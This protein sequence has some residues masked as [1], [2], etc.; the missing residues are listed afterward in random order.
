[1]RPDDIPFGLAL[2][3]IAGWNQLEQDWRRILDLNPQCVYVAEREGTACGTASIMCCSR[4]VA[5]I[6]MV[7]VHPDHR[8][9]GVGSTLMRHCIDVL[10]EAR[11][12]CTKLDATEQGRRVYQKL[13][14]EDERPICRYSL[15]SLPVAREVLHPAIADNDWLSVA[16][17]DHAAFGADRLPLLRHMASDCFTAVA[18]SPKGSRGFGFARIGFNASHLGPIVAASAECAGGL[19]TSLLAQLPAH[20]TVYW[21]GFPD[22]IHARRLAE[23]MG[24]H[25]ER[26]L[27]R[28]RLGGSDTATQAEEIYAAAGFELG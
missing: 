14:F 21:D 1:M 16:K 4:K 8:K 5:W 28:M 26:H 2:C 10:R 9:H 22:N 7:L 12:E 24:F 18:R 13:G 25:A 11:I 20:K 27:T 15:N 19:I 3:R 6:G 17:Q 23:T